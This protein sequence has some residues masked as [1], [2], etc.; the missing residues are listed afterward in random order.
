MWKSSKSIQ[1][2]EEEK[3]E[4][5]VSEECAKGENCIQTIIGY[6]E[7]G[8]VIPRVSCEP[9][10][11]L[12][13]SK[14]K[15]QEKCH[16]LCNKDKNYPFYIWHKQ[17]SGDGRCLFT[18]DPTVPDKNETGD[19]HYGECSVGLLVV[20]GIKLQNCQK[21]AYYGSKLL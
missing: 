19:W 1:I 7:N 14:E 8:E 6:E 9:I 5:K 2:P 18:K 20:L 15:A 3:T 12:E 21:L 17:N 10:R 16:E 4:I 11:D 13:L